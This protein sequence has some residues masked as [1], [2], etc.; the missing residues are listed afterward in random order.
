METNK[1]Y[2]IK[3]IIKNIDNNKIYEGYLCEDL[4]SGYPFYMQ[5]PDDTLIKFESIK[6]AKEFSKKHEKWL[7]KGNN[8]NEKIISLSISRKY[9]DSWIH[10]A[11]LYFNLI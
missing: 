2:C 11:S 4:P 1:E 7:L 3:T 6:A 5:K 9:K 8:S 10:M